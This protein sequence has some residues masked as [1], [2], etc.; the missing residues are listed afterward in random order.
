MDHDELPR[1][2]ISSMHIWL[3]IKSE[4]ARE[5]QAKV[6]AYAKQHRLPPRRRDEMLK[7]S[8]QVIQLED[9]CFL[10]LFHASTWK[11]LSQ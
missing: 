9:A 6:E 3:R 10:F 8:Q 2:S 11:K 4:F 1:I 7:S 5:V